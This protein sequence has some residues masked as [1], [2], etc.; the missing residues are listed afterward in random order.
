MF[1]Q[2]WWASLPNNSNLLLCK[3]FYHN[4]SPSKMAWVWDKNYFMRPPGYLKKLWDK[5]I[6][7]QT[8]RLGL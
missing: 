6:E 8:E 1:E 3:H 4:N 5:E 7:K 2:N